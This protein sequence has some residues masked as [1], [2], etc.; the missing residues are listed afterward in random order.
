MLESRNILGEACVPRHL[1]C[2]FEVVSLEDVYC[3]SIGN[4]ENATRVVEVKATRGEE[5]RE[6]KDQSRL[7]SSCSQ[8]FLLCVLPPP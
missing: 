5:R 2:I 6:A 3:A 4:Q 8:V 7:L 1:R